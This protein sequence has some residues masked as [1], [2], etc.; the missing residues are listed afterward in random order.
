MAIN[1]IGD[2][3]AHPRI[4]TGCLSLD[5]AVAGQDF[6]KNNLLGLPL[7]CGYHI[8]SKDTGLGKTTFSVSLMGIIGC[9]LGKELAISPIDTFDIGNIENI[10]THAGYS[11]DVA[12]V[13]HPDSHSKTLKKLNKVYGDKDVCMALLDSA[14]ACMS[15]AVADGEAEDSN[16]GR[17]A[18]MLATFT[19]QIYGDTTQSKEDKAFII[20]NMLFPEIGGAPR[21]P[22]MPVALS[23]PR[24]RTIPGLTSLHIKL[25]QGYRNNKAVKT[26]SGRL[27]SGK[28]E[29]NNFGPTNREFVVYVV[30]GIGIHVGLTAM[31]DALN[32]GLADEIKGGKVC[33]DGEIIGNISTLVK[34]W[35]D[36]S[37][38][39][40]FITLMKSNKEL[41][42]SGKKKV[43]KKKEVEDEDDAEQTAQELYEG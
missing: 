13:L 43:S 34:S 22:G 24:G 23:T 40:P 8:Y 28:I 14:Y 41:I 39:Q 9:Q 3:P 37:L 15:T 33:I 6:Q 16:M 32:Y 5:L 21:R 30:G 17:D 25:S 4:E 29:K 2:Y 11:G 10:L 26:D 42:S 36:D 19:R 31:Y 20:T 12:I 35:E 18:K 7:R 38:F 1:F 27:L